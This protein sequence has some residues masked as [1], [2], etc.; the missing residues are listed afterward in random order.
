MRLSHRVG[1][2]NDLGFSEICEKDKRGTHKTDTL[3]TEYSRA[4]YG[5]QFALITCENVVLHEPYEECK[6]L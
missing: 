1:D 2:R 6:I 5:C 4:I 3:K